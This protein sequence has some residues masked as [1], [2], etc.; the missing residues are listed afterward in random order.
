MVN[1]KSHKSKMAIPEESSKV[2][3]MIA[4]KEKKIKSIIAEK[5]TDKV[6]AKPVKPERKMAD[7][8]ARKKPTK[9]VPKAKPIE[10]PSEV[11]ENLSLVKEEPKN[12]IT[13]KGRGRPR[14]NP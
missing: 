11:L 8:P 1:E 2:Q 5:E 13:K 3:S 9:Q 7:I 12:E 4:K 14:K 6:E 10:I